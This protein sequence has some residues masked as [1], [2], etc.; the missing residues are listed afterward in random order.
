MR[1]LPLLALALLASVPAPAAQAQGVHCGALP[2]ACQTNV[3]VTIA[4]PA[5]LLYPLGEYMVVPVSIDYTYAP[6]ALTFAPTQV[7]LTATQ[8][9]PW[10]VATISPSTVYMAV[11]P[12]PAGISMQQ[13]PPAQS[14]LLLSAGA[15][16]P[17]FASGVVEVTAVAHG[18]GALNPSSASSQIPVQ[19]AYLGLL[20]VKA[21]SH[22]VPLRPGDGQVVPLRAANLGN[23]PTRVT[24]EVA[25]TPKGV[26]VFPPG[27]L[28]LD[29]P[30]ESD[31]TAATVLLGLNAPG[32]YAPGDVVV[33]ATPAYALDQRWTGEPTRLTLHVAPTGAGSDARVQTLGAGGETLEPATWGFLAAAAAGVALLERR[34]R[35]R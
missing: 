32:R 21:P 13:S 4:A 34:R 7:D 18:N 17:A 12:Q 3:Q 20:E 16:A 19:A 1:A 10:L 9:P 26:E 30:L 29:S 2:Q 11:S 6:T 14:F 33:L 23:A 27:D 24:F 25:S 8:F 31:A 28:N 35:R 15:D 22:V 5:D